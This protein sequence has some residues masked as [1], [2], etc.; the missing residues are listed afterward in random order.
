MNDARGTEPVT[1]LKTKSADAVSLLKILA[2][3]NQEFSEG[4]TLT[5]DEVVQRIERKLEALQSG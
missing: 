4:K 1:V 3:G 5:H 2:K